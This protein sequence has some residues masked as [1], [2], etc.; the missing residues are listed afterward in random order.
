MVLYFNQYGGHLHN[1][2]YSQITSSKIAVILS[3]CLSHCIFSLSLH[4]TCFNPSPYMNTLLCTFRFLAFCFQCHNKSQS[5]TTSYVYFLA[6]LL[7]YITYLC[8]V[9]QNTKIVF[10]DAH[11]TFFTFNNCNWWL[12][13][14]I[15]WQTNCTQVNSPNQHASLTCWDSY[16]IVPIN[17]SCQHAPAVYTAVYYY[18]H[19]S[20]KC[21]VCYI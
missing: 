6:Y 13:D 3:P 5:H 8:T 4:Y 20:V 16:F 18:N 11:V 15:A 10:G 7:F 21:S 1:N 2:N 17:G 9:T 12:L 14:C 19:D